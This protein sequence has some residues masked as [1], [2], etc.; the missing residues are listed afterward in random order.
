MSDIARFNISIF[1]GVLELDHIILE[2][3]IKLNIMQQIKI[4]TETKAVDHV[5]N[6][7]YPNSDISLLKMLKLVKSIDSLNSNT[8]FL[9]SILFLFLSL[10]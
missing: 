5:I 7:I 2:I 6:F 3:D 9:F 10:N 8:Y 4:K 1:I